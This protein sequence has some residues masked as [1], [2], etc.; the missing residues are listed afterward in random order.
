MLLVTSIMYNQWQ[1]VSELLFVLQGTPKASSS[2]DQQF[3]GD[4]VVL[5]LSHLTTRQEVSDSFSPGIIS[6]HIIDSE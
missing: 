2:Y 4:A 3:V 5:L 6:Q 1:L